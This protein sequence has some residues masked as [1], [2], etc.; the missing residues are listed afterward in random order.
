MEV[1]GVLCVDN[2]WAFVRVSVPPF[3]DIVDIVDSMF[4][5]LTTVY[6]MTTIAPTPEPTTDLPQHVRMWATLLGVTSS[7]LAMV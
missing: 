5:A 2:V 4:S 3:D 6:L 1:F 7:V